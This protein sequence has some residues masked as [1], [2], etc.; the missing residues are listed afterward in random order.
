MTGS[1]EREGFF[2]L[3]G[4][5][6]VEKATG[7]R[8]ARIA[9]FA[10][11]IDSHTDYSSAHHP[12]IQR[13][14]SI[15]HAA[16]ILSGAHVQAQ[17]QAGLDSPVAAVSLEH[18]QSREL[19]LWQRGQQI[20]GFDFFGGLVWAVEATGQPGRL[21]HKGKIGAR[22]GGVEDNQSASFSSA[23]VEIAKLDAV[24]LILRGKG[25]ATDL[26]KV[27]A[28]SQRPPFDCL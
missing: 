3:V 6:E 14:G 12:Q 25:R 1:Y 7:R 22:C 21:L 15:A 17:V 26:C 19:G 18:L 23:A 2:A 13:A 10:Y 5:H 20:F 9:A 16:A 27:V 8:F 11:P 4:G 24:R 28:R